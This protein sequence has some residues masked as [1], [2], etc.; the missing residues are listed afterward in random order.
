MGGVGNDA[1]ARSGTGGVVQGPVGRG[2]ACSRSEESAR[3][4]KGL[5]AA[6]G[7]SE[8]SPTGEAWRGPSMAV[9]R[10]VRLGTVHGPG[11]SAGLLAL[12]VRLAF[13][14]QIVGIVLKTVDQGLRVETVR[15]LI[16]PFL[17]RTVRGH[18]HRS[19]PVP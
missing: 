4:S 12:P 11:G 18:D 3:L 2:A 10:P 14:H 5:W 7:G 19:L 8:A 15:E 17:W 16:Q 1:V 13:D 6:V 9:H